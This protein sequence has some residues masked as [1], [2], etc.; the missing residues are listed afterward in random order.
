MGLRQWFLKK[1][2]KKENGDK[3]INELKDRINKLQAI[4]VLTHR[5]LL[6]TLFNISC[7]LLF[8]ALSCVVS[9]IIFGVIGVV[10][11]LLS[12]FTIIALIPILI[13]LY[14]ILYGKH[15][16]IICSNCRRIKYNNKF[17]VL[18]EFIGNLSHDICAECARTETSIGMTEKKRQHN[19]GKYG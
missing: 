16:L 3:E 10:F 8:T 17:Y 5:T 12:V 18:E 19:G 2:K 14:L 1:C 7:V 4:S 15:T 9:F 13:L 11:K 6:K